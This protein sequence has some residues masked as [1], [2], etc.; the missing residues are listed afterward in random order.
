MVNKTQSLKEQKQLILIFP[1]GA[2][3]DYKKIVIMS[4]DLEVLFTEPGWCTDNTV[5]L[6]L[7]GALFESQ[8]GFIQ[9]S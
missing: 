3:D 4:V 7:E 1:K 8:L 5:D 2:A 6:Y 9:C